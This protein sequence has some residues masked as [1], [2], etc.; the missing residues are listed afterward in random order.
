MLLRRG[1]PGETAARR[2]LRQLVDRM[3]E[4]SRRVLRSDPDLARALWLLDLAMTKDRHQKRPRTINLRCR[5]TIAASV[6]LALLGL[7]LILEATAVTGW[8]T[9]KIERALAL[10]K[11]LPSAWA[12]TPHPDMN[13][14]PEQ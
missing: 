6:L 1:P 2:E 13:S 5:C 14:L 11:H 4:T 12:P 3:D 7:F 9:G 8:W 10:P